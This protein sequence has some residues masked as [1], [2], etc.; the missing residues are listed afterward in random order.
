ML[1]RFELWLS[2]VRDHQSGATEGE[3]PLLDL[4]LSEKR[5]PHG[6]RFL[7]FSKVQPGVF[8]L[9][10]EAVRPCRLLGVRRLCLAF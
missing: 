8:N 2:E 5:E 6:W 4:W 3:V 7:L 1:A 10:I 9:Q